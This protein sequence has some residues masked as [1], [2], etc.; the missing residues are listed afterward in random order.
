ML[1]NLN[2]DFKKIKPVMTSRNNY[3]TFSDKLNVLITNL[4]E[5]VYE[6]SVKP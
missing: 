6:S 3:I 2:H 4:E 1:K 5:E